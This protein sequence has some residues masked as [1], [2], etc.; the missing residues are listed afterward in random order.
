[1][2]EKKYCEQCISCF[3][4]NDRKSH[5]CDDGRVESVVSTSI[6]V[7]CCIEARSLGG[8]CGPAAKYWE[9]KT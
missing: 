5:F 6:L 3:Y 8:D 9:L 7:T 2:S 4:D 1:V